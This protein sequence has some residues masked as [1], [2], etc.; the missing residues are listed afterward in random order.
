MRNTSY[1]RR[2]WVLVEKGWK[3]EHTGR[4][5]KYINFLSCLVFP[6]ALVERASELDV[7]ASSRT[8][9]EMDLEG[10]TESMDG[11]FQAHLGMA[12]DEFKEQWRRRNR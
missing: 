1:G 9:A 10:R 8:V 3:G 11:A 4:V 2:N 6:N 7:A 12:D 5:S